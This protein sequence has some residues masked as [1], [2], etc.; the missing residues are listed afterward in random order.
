[1]RF[2]WAAT[3]NPRLI[4][5]TKLRCCNHTP[6]NHPRS[7]RRVLE[8]GGE[9]QLTDAL[10]ARAPGHGDAL[11]RVVPRVTS[12]AQNC[13]ELAIARVVVD[14]RR[15]QVLMTRSAAGAS[16]VGNLQKRKP[17]PTPVRAVVF[18]EFWPNRHL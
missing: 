4:E 12:R 8:L 9:P 5:K 7:V 11:R 17:V 18:A 2:F 10:C 16:I 6:W 13:N 14:M 1:M 3:S 15:I